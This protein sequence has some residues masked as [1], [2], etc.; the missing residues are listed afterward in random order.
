[1]WFVRKSFSDVNNANTKQNI[2]KLAVSKI[3]PLVNLA[4]V[5]CCGYQSNASQNI[6]YKEK[7]KQWQK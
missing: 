3:L 2:K 1:M 7:R 6:I 4:A 5:V